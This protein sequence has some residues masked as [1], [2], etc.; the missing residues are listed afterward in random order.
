MSNL[1]RREVIDK[2]SQRH[3]GDV[4]LS[5]PLS[6]WAITL[7]IAIIMA[8]LVSVAI[9]GEYS[10]KERV[11][12]VLTPSDGLVRILPSQ[13]G[14]FENVYVQTGDTVEAGAPL[15]KVKDDTVLTGGRQLSE[16]LLAQMKDEREGLQN[17]LEEIP[18]QYR[19]SQ[20]RLE[21]RK[22]ELEAEAERFVEQIDAQTRAVII[23]EDIFRKF[24]DLLENEAASNIEVSSAENRYLSATQS[25]N[26]LKNSREK[27]LAESKDVDG[28]LA[29]LPIEQS[30]AKR[31]IKNQ[32]SN[33]EQ[34][35]LRTDAGGS[36][37]IR[38]P[39]EGS[40]ATVTA[41]KGQKASP[42]RTAIAILPKGGRLQAELLV[43]TRAIGFVKTGQP[44]R[45][46]YD[47]FP[48][49]KFGFYD[50]TITEVSK[51]VVSGNDLE[52]A[53]Q[54][55]EPVFL[56]TVDLVEQSIEALGQDVPLQA[57]MSLSAD[58]ILEDRKIWEWAF[59]PLLG[60][61]K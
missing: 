31:D 2:Q 18:T 19:L 61:L 38:A 11:S 17:R 7:L 6:F 50:G 29:M 58:L 27:I 54:L 52:I 40:I 43:P 3:L 35:I 28:Q 22:M 60:A 39:I 23:E 25:L 55:P 59:E 14:N 33:L 56:V 41:R 48:Y 37:I 30:Q 1:F 21:T 44:V 46:L 34:T 47:A 8:G 45:L 20:V 10:R 4:F 51:T 49:Q 16:A 13:S 15:L 36:S 12:G 24:Q 26:S 32:L 5:S 42:Q 57:G 53:R 9:F